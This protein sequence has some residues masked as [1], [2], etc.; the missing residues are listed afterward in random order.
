VRRSMLHLALAALVATAGCGDDDS[1]TAANSDATV[2][3]ESADTATDT[4]TNSSAEASTDS[5]TEASADT[6]AVI[7]PGDGG[8]YDV[9]IDPADF[10]SVVDNPFFPMLPGS[11]WKYDET[12]A[13]GEH[14]T[15]TVEVLEQ[16]RKVMGV[17]T[18]VVHDVAENEDGDVEEDTFDWYA[19]DSE[20]NVW[21]F[22]EDTTS[23]DG[24]E[25]S[26]EG[27]WEAGVDGALPGIVMQARPAVSSTGYRQEYLA[28]V[29]EDMAQVIGDSGNVTVPYGTFDDVIR[30]REWSPVEPDIV[31][32][33]T[34]A[35]SIGVVHEETV[36]SPEGHEEVV[37]VAFT[38]PG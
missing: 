26:K 8:N 4:S 17:D 32:E 34:Y 11:V 21:Y 1:S 2:G 37:L 36:S 31:E 12:T 10:S 14:Q 25:T 13:D 15:D 23:Y 33:K 20:G 18:I 29:A 28:G 27:S 16:H 38:P 9:E 7:D 5:S 35:R 6:S 24:G 3:T 30:T 22:G 19:Q